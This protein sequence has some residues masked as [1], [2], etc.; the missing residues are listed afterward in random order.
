MDGEVYAR[1]PHDFAP[2]KER[3]IVPRPEVNSNLKVGITGK[4]SRGSYHPQKPILAI[5]VLLY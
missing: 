1:P 4:R 5:H 2:G 3:A